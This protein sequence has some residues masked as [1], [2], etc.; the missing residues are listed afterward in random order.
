M[1]VQLD[2]WLARFADQVELILGSTDDGEGALVRLELVLSNRQVVDLNLDLTTLLDS[3]SIRRDGHV[4][5]DL[6]FPHEVEVELSIV[7]KDDLL[8][9]PLVDEEFSEVKLG[10][11]V[12][13][14]FDLWLVSKDCVM[15]FVA[16]AL[17]VQHKRPCLTFDIT[18]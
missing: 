4:L 16:F 2:T 11:L 8:S 10:G 3:A 6:T 7:C 15:N 5:V 12:S 18:V 1:L 13:G 14:G 17:D 9:F